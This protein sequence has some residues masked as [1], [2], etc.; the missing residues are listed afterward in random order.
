MMSNSHIVAPH[1]YR[2]IP[3]HPS[4]VEKTPAFFF[5]VTGAH[6]DVLL[7]AMQSN[8]I[9]KYNLTFMEN[10]HYDIVTM[11]DSSH[12][13]IIKS[14]LRRYCDGWEDNIDIIRG[15]VDKF[16][17][18]ETRSCPSPIF[19][20]NKSDAQKAVEDEL[21]RIDTTHQDQGSHKRTLYEEEDCDIFNIALDEDNH[22]DEQ[23]D[24]LPLPKR[25][26][27]N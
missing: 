7:S 11:Y 8:N 24:L 20:F 1:K 27:V 4:C 5:K 12:V 18:T 22:E 15:E 3:M 16:Q 21:A 17:N 13:G 14:Y 26:R 9:S 2:A 25:M 19:D 6:L 23:A 10:K